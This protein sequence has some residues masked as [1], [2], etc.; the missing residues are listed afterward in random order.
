MRIVSQRIPESND[1]QYERGLA[2]ARRGLMRAV[3]AR[4]RAD[5]SFA[6]RERAM[7]AAANEACRCLLESALQ[8]TADGHPDRVRIEGIEYARHQEGAVTYHSLCGPLTVRRATYREV[9]EHNG[10]T[11]VPVEL[12]AGLLEGA[13][14]ALAYR[15]ALGYAQGPGR[16]AEEQMHA[17][18]RQPPSRS[19]LERL[20][21]AIGTAVT[22]TA[23]RIEPVVREAETLPAGTR[24]ISIG[25]DRTTVPMEEGRPA[26]TPPATRRKPRIKPYIRTAPPPV[27]VKYRMAYVGTVSLVD[28]AGEA[29]IT[30]R[31]AITREDDAGDLVS[32]MMADV[33]RAR[34]QAPR[35][36]VGVI[37]DA[38]PEL[39]TLVRGGLT[40]E[41]RLRQWEDA[42]DRYHLNERLAEILRITEPE[43]ARRAQQ[44]TRWNDALDRDDA[45][46][47]RIARWLAERI[48]AYEGD[49]LAILEAHWTFIFNNN[50]RLRYATVRAKGL[51]CGSGATEGA[52]KSVIMIRAKGCGQRWHQDGVTAVLTLRAAYL[53]E[54]LGTLWPHFAD[55]YSAEIQPAA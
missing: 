55:E 10:P 27:D 29:L 24:G 6:D 32:R 38:A 11:V 22:R 50:D 7:L 47:D 33:H 30:R 19:T 3:A 37:Q 43:T 12:A 26:G 39:W 21:K 45:T 34:A 17:D 9:G 54:R 46:I 28:G 1:N 35:L 41:A 42:I 16:H 2:D 18:H 49:E 23:P 48:P 31:Y 5:A 20:G 52:C 15:V 44:L 25:I 53:S 4:V 51:P 14:P 36:P 40:T 13:T 8:A